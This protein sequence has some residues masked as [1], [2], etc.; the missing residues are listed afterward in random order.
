MSAEHMAES[1]ADQNGVRVDDDGRPLDDHRVASNTP[2]PRTRTCPPFGS[3]G[4]CGTDDSVIQELQLVIV[5]L[6]AL[7]PPSWN[8][9]YA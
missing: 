1:S 6:S 8:A 4:A 2:T 5:G 3:G 7:S 9:F